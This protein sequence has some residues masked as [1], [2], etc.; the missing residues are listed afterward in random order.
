[1]LVSLIC[2]NFMVFIFIVRHRSRHSED[3]KIKKS[4]RR[5]PRRHSHERYDSFS[6]LDERARYAG[7]RKETLL[8]GSYSDYLR[9]YQRS[10]HSS[11]PVPVRSS[12]HYPPRGVDLPPYY[13][14]PVHSS[15]SRSSYHRPVDP[16]AAAC[17]EFLRRTQSD[18]GDRGH[19][20]SRY[21]SGRRR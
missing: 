18:R 5:G 4:R 11:A 19:G 15:S 6:R 21:R 10:R 8:H 2:A 14:L 3:H 7:V 17:D 13:A 20:H 16:Y 12:S 9:D 1:M